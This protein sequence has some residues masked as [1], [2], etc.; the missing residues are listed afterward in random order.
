MK[1][2]SKMM[3]PHM[4]DAQ[5][6]AM[7]LFFAKDQIQQLTQ[8]LDAI[9]VA[10]NERYTRGLSLVNE[11]LKE[12]PAL[13]NIKEVDDLLNLMIISTHELTQ[14]IKNANHANYFV[15]QDELR[16]Y[17]AFKLIETIQSELVYF[18]DQEFK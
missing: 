8:L 11:Q 14:V 13:M 12:C 2:M 5:N 4:Y 1:M 9:I 3:K 7:T 16:I 18:E 15:D 6:G 17:R 10:N